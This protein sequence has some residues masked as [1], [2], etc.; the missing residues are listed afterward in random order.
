MDALDLSKRP[1]RSPRERVGGLYMLARTIDKLRALQPGGNPNGYRVAGMSQRLL[2]TIGISA[3]DLAA[4]VAQAFDDD[5]VAAWVHSHA[6]SSKYSAA[7]ELLSK[8]SVADTDQA[9]FFEI[10]P[11]VRESTLTNLF[12]VLEE[13]DRRTYTARG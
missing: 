8:R 12:D 7:N 4:I 9:R 13:D 1:P 5:D 6:D 11:W 10:Y 3:D 2:D